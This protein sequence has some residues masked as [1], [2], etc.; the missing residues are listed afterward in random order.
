MRRCIPL[1]LAAVALAL[2]A[3]PARAQTTL[4]YQ[5]KEGQR[6]EYAVDQD[7]KMAM[8][9]MGMD[10]DMKMTQHIDLAW[11][12]VKVDADGNATVKIRFD[13]VKMAMDGPTG[14]VEADSKD[15][16][17]AADPVGK[18][19]NQIVTALAALDM[20]LVMTPVGEIKKVDVPEAAIKK[21]KQLPGLDKF[22]GDMFSPEGLKKMAQGGGGLLLPK[23]AVKKGESWTQKADQKTPF[24]KMTGDNKYT[25]EGPVEKDGRTLQKIALK[26]DMKIEPSPDAPVKITIKGQEGK[27]TILFD[28]AAG[29][30]ASLTNELTMRLEVEVNDM[31]IDQ[32]IV[33]T[34]TMRLKGT[35]V[36]KTS[37][38]KK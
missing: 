16:K 11:N 23:D 15:A 31:T 8:K 18:I 4:R 19:F 33:Q 24:G 32:R 12:V 21:F 27:G 2:A 29:H 5:L 17:E 7:M 37:S 20:T 6:L 14:N 26:P 38:E 28:N 30:I 35:G 3:V 25:Y 9:V 34:T 10:L 13:R 22:G 36:G 1:G